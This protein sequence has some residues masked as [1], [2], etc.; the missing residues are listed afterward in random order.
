[1]RV[2]LAIPSN[3]QGF[4]FRYQARGGTTCHGPAHQ[5]RELELN[6]ALTGRGLAADP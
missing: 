5:H 6:V 4:L 1:M 2:R 3:R